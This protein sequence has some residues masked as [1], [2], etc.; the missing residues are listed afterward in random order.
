MEYLGKYTLPAVPFAGLAQEPEGSG[1]NSVINI[2]L[3]APNQKGL[4]GH[5]HQKSTRIP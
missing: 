3:P 5:A 2:R 4:L 1:G